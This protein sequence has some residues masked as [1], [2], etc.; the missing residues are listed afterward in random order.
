[1]IVKLTIGR[2]RFT[3]SMAPITRVIGVDSILPDGN[4]ILMW[5]FDDISLDDVLTSL[6][7]VQEIY[8]LPK[9]YIFETKPNSNYIA[10][11]FKRVSWKKA[12]E[13]VVSTRHV[14]MSFYK[15]GV[16]RDKFTLRVGPKCGRK[17]K[18]VAVLPSDFP[19]DVLIDELR[20]WVNYETLADGYIGKEYK[21]EVGL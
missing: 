8:C 12:L 19:E 15:Y 13:I 2:W 20:S 5:D 3:F 4:H 14:C 9:I 10:Y 7:E 1:M 21:L 17:P 16:M 6:L 11:C 18:L